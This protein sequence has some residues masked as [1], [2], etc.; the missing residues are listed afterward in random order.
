M[1]TTRCG[2][3]CGSSRSGAGGLWT[4]MVTAPCESGEGRGRSGI[5]RGVAQGVEKPG[6][7][8]FS[9]TRRVSRVSYVPGEHLSIA[10]TGE[11]SLA[12]VVITLARN[13]VATSPTSEQQSPGGSVGPGRKPG[14][15]GRTTRSVAT[16]RAVISGTDLRSNQSRIVGPAIDEPRVFARF[17]RD[18]GGFAV[19][20]RQLW[21]VAHRVRVPDSSF[22]I[23]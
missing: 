18:G 7:P 9:P 21:K 6:M 12:A 1:V 20:A 2:E 11:R 23:K 22:A 13:R 16:S 5:G 3:A 15:T 14:E 17:C 19:P 8:Q 4:D 10:S